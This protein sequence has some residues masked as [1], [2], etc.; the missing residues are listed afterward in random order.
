V[1]CQ[2]GSKC[3]RV[4]VWCGGVA[5]IGVARRGVAGSVWHVVG[6]VAGRGAGGLCEPA[7]SRV[8]AHKVRHLPI[9]TTGGG[10]G[11]G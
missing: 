2:K 6:T 10:W 3:L 1:R 11:G 4:L 5:G 8:C 7:V 9:R